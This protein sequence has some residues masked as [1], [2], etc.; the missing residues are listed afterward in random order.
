M[1]IGMCIGA[2]G[3][4]V[5]PFAVMAGLAACGQPEVATAPPVATL[6]PDVP[7]TV[8]GGEI[9]GAPA[10]GNPDIVAFKGVPYAA[11]PV[12][13]L[14]WKPPQPV[15]AWDGVRDATAPGPTSTS[16]RRERVGRRAP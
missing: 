14:R 13:D 9:L 4:R 10:A 12:G 8:A 3:R 11:P 6:A 15:V 2:H 5:L 7:V 1:R 16:G